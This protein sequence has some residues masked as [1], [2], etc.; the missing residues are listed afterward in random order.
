MNRSWTGKDG[1]INRP[2][3]VHAMDGLSPFTVLELNKDEVALLNNEQDLLNTS[4]LVSVEDLRLQQRTLNIF[5]PLEAD[6]LMLM[7]KRYGN[8]LFDVFQTRAHSLRRLERKSV[9]SASV[10]GKQESV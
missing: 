2:S 7:L 9:L 3:L 5:I 1:K 4:S 6:D 10:Q 8:L